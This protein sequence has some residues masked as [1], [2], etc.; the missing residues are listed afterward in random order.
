MYDIKIDTVKK[1]WDSVLEKMESQLDVNA[2]NTFF[3]PI[4]AKEIK[5]NKL[6]V[7][8]PTRFVKEVV[9]S[10]MFISKINTCLKELTNTNLELEV[11]EKSEFEKEYNSRKFN[12]WHRWKRND[13]AV[14]I[15][16]PDIDLVSKNTL[17]YIVNAFPELAER[18]LDFLG[19]LGVD[20]NATAPELNLDASAAEKYIV[21]LKLQRHLAKL[22][23]TK[24][25]LT[26]QLLGGD[27]SVRDEIAQID[28]DIAKY[29]EKLEILISI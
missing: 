12:T 29:S 20:F 25:E 22:Q 6:L 16:L 5:N 7:E 21:S 23:A 26:N 10:E 8:A 18:Y 28:A 4:V 14:Q 13:S 11:K 9:S 2:F 19:T 17:V 1:I 27:E 15:K 3:L 24:K